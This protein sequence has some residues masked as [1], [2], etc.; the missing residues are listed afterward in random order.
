MDWLERNLRGM[1][2]TLAAF[3]EGSGAQLLELDGL[4]ATVNPAVA[5]RSVFNS[6]VYS[7]LEALAARRDEL[8]AIYADAGCAWTVWVP[9]YDEAS[10]RM[11]EGAGHTRDAQPRAMGVELVAL[12]EPDLSGIDWT[13]EGDAE[14]MAALN[15]GAYG[16]PA[17][18]WIKG[19]G[20]DTP[21]LRT[22]IA[23]NDGRPAATVGVRDVEGDCTVWNVATAESARGRGLSTALMR[24]AMFDAE[25]RGCPTSTLQATKLGAPVYRRCG[26]EDFGALQMWEWRPPELAGQAHPTPAARPGA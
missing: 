25:Q 24:K 5:E 16:Y 21:G 20:R 12:T 7:D 26:Y 4:I 8:A 1:R 23:R 13:A 19:M 15:D 2:A 9:E 11:L 14:E 22:Y 18:T 3:A 6:V 17:G 10:A